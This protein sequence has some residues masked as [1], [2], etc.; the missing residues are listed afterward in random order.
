MESKCFFAW[1][2][3]TPPPQRAKHPVHCRRREERGGR[4][5]IALL[6]RH[7]SHNAVKKW[8][9]VSATNKYTTPNCH[10]FSTHGCQA[11][12]F[13]HRVTTASS[14]KHTYT[15]KALRI[16]EPN[17]NSIY[18]FQ[19]ARWTAVGKSALRGR[20]Y[21]SPTLLAFSTT[22]TYRLM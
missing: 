11:L 9:S 1:L 22:A 6:Q 13:F 12:F 14:N 21:S 5:E 2:I 20:M 19:I 7:L 10:A 16:N 3:P 15:K 17:H 4:G 8:I 18:I